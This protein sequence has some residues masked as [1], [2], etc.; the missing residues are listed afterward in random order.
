[1]LSEIPMYLHTDTLTHLYKQSYSLNSPRANTEIVCNQVSMQKRSTMLNFEASTG[2]SKSKTK[3]QRI[4]PVHKEI[5]QKQPDTKL[6]RSQRIHHAG[7]KP[8]LR[9]FS[10]IYL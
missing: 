1:M 5:L 6:N 7:N 2:K 9:S 4:K 10:T 8:R 3:V